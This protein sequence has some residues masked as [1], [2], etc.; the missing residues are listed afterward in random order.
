MRQLSCHF[1][2][3]PYL[4]GWQRRNH[5]VIT[6]LEKQ[7]CIRQLTYNSCCFR[8][9]EC[10]ASESETEKTKGEKRESSVPPGYY[11]ISFYFSQPFLHALALMMLYATRVMARTHSQ[12]RAR[13]SALLC[14]SAPFRFSGSDLH[15]CARSGVDNWP[16]LPT[17]HKCLRLSTQH[18]NLLS[19]EFN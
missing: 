6:T 10:A 1:G 7:I 4:D 14:R 2:L 19:P 8:P 18:N 13:W 11:F 12:R 15:G 16:P 9:V 3:T 5:G 17:Y